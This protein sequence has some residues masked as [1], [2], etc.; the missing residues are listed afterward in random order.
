MEDPEQED[1]EMVDAAPEEVDQY[2]VLACHG[3]VAMASLVTGCGHM[4]CQSCV[5]TFV[6]PTRQCPVCEFHVCQK[7]VFSIYSSCTKKDYPP[8]CGICLESTAPQALVTKCGH[9]FCK[10]CLEH[11]FDSKYN[12]PVCREHACPKFSIP[13][14]FSSITSIMNQCIGWLIAMNLA[15][16]IRG[17]VGCNAIFSLLRRTLCESGFNFPIALACSHTSPGQYQ[18]LNKKY[19]LHF[20]FCRPSVIMCSFHNFLC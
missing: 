15:F 7:M 5:N 1:V 12:C 10:E 6:H 18:I 2:L 8:Q 19:Y 17:G 20:M 9:L 4:F 11:W 16:Y 3:C 14:G 13:I